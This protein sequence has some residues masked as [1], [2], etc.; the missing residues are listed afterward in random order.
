[1]NGVGT[2]RFGVY[3]N[4]YWDEHGSV[5]PAAVEQARLAEDLGFDWLVLGERHLHRPGYHEILSSAAWLAAHT[6]RIGIATAG[7]ILPV[8]PPAFLAETLAHLDVLSGGRLTAGF[9]LGYRAEEFSMFETD[10]RHRRGLFEEGLRIVKRLWAGERVTFHGRHHH[11]DDVFIAPL[12]T[13][14]PRPRIWNGGRVEAALRR[15]AG[16][17]DGWTTSFNEEQDEL[18]PKI[19]AYRSLPNGPDSLGSEVIVLRDGFCAPTSRSARETL[20]EPLLELYGEYANW[21]RGSVDAGRYRGVDWDTAARRLVVGSPQ[22][23]LEE[24]EAY[25]AMGADGVVLRVQPPGLDQSATLRCLELLGTHVLPHFSTDPH[26]A[27]PSS[28]G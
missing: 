15:T 26:P 27:V 24:L 3:L 4:L 5:M 23:V 16:E 11:L 17:C 21:K 28:G 8:Y 19:A 18:A 20:E 25:R 7:I 10:Q 12:P 6:R 9:V 2:L 14:R 13:Q 1:M 22:Q